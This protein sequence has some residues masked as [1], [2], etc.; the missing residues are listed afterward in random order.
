[1]TVTIPAVYRTAV[2]AT[3][4]ERIRNAA[5]PIVIGVRRPRLK[6]GTSAQGKLHAETGAF[7]PEAGE[8]GELVVAESTLLSR[9]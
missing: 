8:N 4:A 9:L 5:Y 1:M 7:P 2:S 6:K 3:A